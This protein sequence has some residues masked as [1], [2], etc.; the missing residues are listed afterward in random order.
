MFSSR[1]WFWIRSEIEQKQDCVSGLVT[2][3]YEAQL[4]SIPQKNSY[5]ERNCLRFSAKRFRCCAFASD[6]QQSAF[7][8]QSHDWR[9]DERVQ[10]VLRNTNKAS[11]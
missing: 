8:D 3:F 9:R 2:E 4:E 6:V 7:C 5:S 11:S 10:L 1:R